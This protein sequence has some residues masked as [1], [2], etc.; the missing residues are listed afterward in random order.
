L[1]DGSADRFSDAETIED[2][3][4]LSPRKKIST[5]GR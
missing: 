2:F 3:Q 4:R 1:L 5:A